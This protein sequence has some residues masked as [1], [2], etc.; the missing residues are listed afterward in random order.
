MPPRSARVPSRLR[1]PSFA[2]AYLTA[3]FCSTG[4]QVSCSFWTKARTCSGVMA[5]E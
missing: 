1:Q 4:S 3:I 2:R 5:R